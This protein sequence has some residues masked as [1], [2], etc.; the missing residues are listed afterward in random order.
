MAQAI[1]HNPSFSYAW[2]GLG[3][4]YLKQQHYDSALNCLQISDALNPGN[5]RTCNYLGMTHYRIGN[6][7]RAEKL[8]LE[9]YHLR[10]SDP[11]AP[12]NLL[13]LY[14]HQERGRDYEALLVDV[15]SRDNAPVRFV[16]ML[17]ECQ[18]GESDFEAAAGNLR[19]ALTMGL[20]SASVRALQAEYP[21]LRVIE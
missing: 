10:P 13:R 12:G 21:Q 14:C 8:W 3:F 5:F 18:L 9:A 2:R 15:A 6:W 7:D 19:R 1:K 16:R 11:Y 4:S 17:A 20:D